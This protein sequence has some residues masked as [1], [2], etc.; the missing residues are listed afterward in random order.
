[1]GANDDDEVDYDEDE[2]EV[3]KQTRMDEVETGLQRSS[4]HEESGNKSDQSSASKKSSERHSTSKKW[5]AKGLRKPGWESSS[6]DESIG[7]PDNRRSPMTTFRK[8]KGKACSSSEPEE[9][10]FTDAERIPFLEDVF[11]RMMVKAFLF[12]DA[13]SPHDL[14]PLDWELSRDIIHQ[15]ADDDDYNGDQFGNTG[16]ASKTLHYLHN[17]IVRAYSLA[18]KSDPRFIDDLEIIWENEPKLKDFYFDLICRVQGT[19]D[20][21][22]DEKKKRLIEEKKKRKAAASGPGVKDTANNGNARGRRAVVDSDTSSEEEEEVEEGPIEH[23]DKLSTKEKTKA[24][25][26][27]ALNMP[28]EELLKMQRKEFERWVRKENDRTFHE[29]V[30]RGIQGAGGTIALAPAPTPVELDIVNYGQLGKVLE[31]LQ[32]LTR[33]KVECGIRDVVTERARKQIVRTLRITGMTMEGESELNWLDLPPSKFK[34]FFDLL[35]RLFP[36]GVEKSRTAGGLIEMLKDKISSFK[37]NPL[38]D[39]SGKMQIF[40]DQVDTEWGLLEESDRTADNFRKFQTKVLFP[41]LSGCMVGEFGSSLVALMKEGKHIQGGTLAK[42]PDQFAIQVETLMRQTMEDLKI[43]RSRMGPSDFGAMFD[44]FLKGKDCPHAKKLREEGGFQRDDGRQVGNKQKR[45]DRVTFGDQPIPKK[46][47]SQAARDQRSMNDPDRVVCGGCGSDNHRKEDCRM[48]K[49]PDWNKEDVPFRQSAA[50]ATLKE[51]NSSKPYLTQFYRADGTPC[52][53]QLVFKDDAERAEYEASLARKKAKYQQQQ[54]SSGGG[55]GDHRGGGPPSGGQGGGHK[56]NAFKGKQQGEEYAWISA[57]QQYIIPDTT[58]ELRVT[59][60]CML[61]L[62]VDQPPISVNILI[63]SGCLQGNLMSPAVHK[64]L[65]AQSKTGSVGS[66]SAV[67]MNG[68]G[69]AA[70]AVPP[71]GDLSTSG[72]E[73]G[74]MAVEG[75]VGASGVSSKRAADTTPCCSNCSSAGVHCSTCR[76]VEADKM[77]CSPLGSCVRA[78][79]AMH[80]CVMLFNE[81]VHDFESL[82]V[83]VHTMEVAPY[84]M[85]LGLEAIRK[86]DIF[87]KIPSFFGHDP[88]LTVH[89]LEE[90]ERM[91]EL[92][93]ARSSG[94]AVVPQL[95]DVHNRLLK[96]SCVDLGQ[97]DL[98][99]LNALTGGRREEIVSSREFFEYEQRDTDEIEYDEDEDILFRTESSKS[100]DEF[101][102]PM[103]GTEE[104]AFRAQI[105]D[106]CLE[107]KD[108][109]STELR[110][111]P[112]DITPMKIVLQK[113]DDGEDHWK[114]ARNRLP[115]RLQSPKKQEAILQ[116]V[117]VMEANNIIRPSNAT[118][119]SQVLLREKPDGTYR[120]CVDFRRLNDICEFT[121][122]WPIPNIQSML[123]RIGA[124]KAQYY[125]LMDLTKGYYQTALSWES[126]YLT[127]FIVF[128]GT[129]EWLRVAMGLKGAP[130][131]FQRGMIQEVLFGLVCFIC[132]IYMDDVLIYALTQA[133]YIAN[134]RKVFERF[135]LKK[136]CANPKKC[137][138]GLTKATWVGHVI[139]EGGKTFSSDKR[140][141]VLEFPLPKTVK[142]LRSFL[143]LINFFRDHMKDHSTRVGPLQ[144]MLT[145]DRNKMLEWSEDTIKVFMQ[146]KEDVSNC[147][148][149]WFVDDNSPIHLETDASDYGWGCFLYQL[150]EDNQRHVIVFISKTFSDLQ[151]RWS[152]Y[153]KEAYAIY[154]SFKKLAYLLR[155]VHF[156]LHTDHRNLLYITDSASAKVI[157]WKL[158]IMEYN[159]D[160]QH[161]KGVDNCVADAMSRLCALD[162][163]FSVAMALSRLCHEDAFPDYSEV[164]LA[165]LNAITFK[166]TAENYDR[167]ALAHNEFVG[168]HGV[169][170]TIAKLKT[171]NLHWKGR[172][173]DVK[174]FV[175]H[176]PFCQKCRQE[177]V[178]VNTAPFVTATLEPMQMINIDTIGP[179]NKG[180]PDEK[181][182]TVLID[183]FARFVELYVTKDTKAKPAARCLLDFIG[184]YGAPEYLKSDNGSQFVNEVIEELLQLV[185]TTHLQTL[186][187]SKQENSIVERA[188]KEVMRHLRALIFTKDNVAMPDWEECLPLVQ[189]IMNASVHSSIGVSPAQLIFG[190]SLQLDRGILI[191]HSIRDNSEEPEALSDWAKRMYER[192][193]YLLN[194]ARETQSKE[195]AHHLAIRQAAVDE[196]GGV[197]EFPVNSYVLVEY[198]NRPP[199]KLNTP[200]KGPLRVVSHIGADYTLENLVD[201]R[202][203]HV[204]ASKLRPFEFDPRFVDPRQVANKEQEAYDVES[205]LSHTGDRKDRKTLKFRVKW[206]GYDLDNTTYEPWKNLMHTSAL[207]RYLIA[208]KLKGL[209]PTQY[210]YMYPDTWPNVVPPPDANQMDVVEAE[211]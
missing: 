199:S 172:W 90:I 161:I 46:N 52:K 69:G 84:E 116:Q 174:D 15:F 63:D 32:H 188:N 176:C 170:R 191:P 142:A 162:E 81:E 40:L 107:F 51:K 96:N 75:E 66:A 74:S 167:I 78:T 135:R 17:S 92:K 2:V 8:K 148:K 131:Y 201:N 76:G 144:A 205:I 91:I 16:Y 54:Q 98:A 14:D 19:A 136:V 34:A 160:I 155:D 72:G 180:T 10:K 70:S 123:D 156:I 53:V 149:L 121:S 29:H 11:L 154:A 1:M 129:F 59:V 42:N 165:S 114:H 109:F 196:S 147:P 21:L 119:Y 100:G 139:G 27:L 65:L 145:P 124:K 152:T 35:R 12:A 112:A 68:D 4:I 39:T 151:R 38:S 134:L 37:V 55:K 111:E 120:F 193:E 190:N 104:P 47:D 24:V 179:I 60:P 128:F 184:R 137:K 182:I 36:R 159:F 206:V 138:F 168:H 99:M 187:Y 141:E 130:S 22:E 200:L 210:R 150:T 113:F 13:Q 126:I 20:A 140:N 163:R 30:Q 56:G 23:F 6:D 143:G 209:V 79:D 177:T 9:H 157:R 80:V 181:Y 7:Y 25:K 18:G 133:E 33:C 77:V 125:G 202:V 117:R 89:K 62:N 58:H 175:K 169:A 73:R 146:L 132:E 192:Q 31:Y 103:I 164:V 115:C 43:M 83:T 48:R 122:G 28:V 85:I 93:K 197:T 50:Y 94:N 97:A 3:E 153:E 5:E 64:A 204:H 198:H 106:L 108:I 189:R 203:S 26:A 82:L 208:N 127:C 194:R 183:C 49:H 88:Q 118:E 195:D 101:V 71:V 110:R 171:M 166:M 173:R 186:S 67:S 185:G 158:Q 57:M 211:E 207:H 61:S 45:G 95:V 178:L 86:Y 41:I 105:E 44:N 87:R 102:M